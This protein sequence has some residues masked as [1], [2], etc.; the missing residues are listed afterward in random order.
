[1]TFREAYELAAKWRDEAYENYLADLS[2]PHDEMGR[3]WRLG[4]IMR[5]V[6]QQCM[7]E[8]ATDMRSV[9]RE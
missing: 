5:A 1:M 2:D 9:D 4:D 7:R 6:H 3:T 8:A